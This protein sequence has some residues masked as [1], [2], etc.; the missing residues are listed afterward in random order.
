MEPLQNRF[1]HQFILHAMGDAIISVDLNRQILWVNPAFTHLFGYDSEEV[2]HRSVEFVYANP[3]DFKMQGKLRY[4]RYVPSDPRPYEMIY[5]RKDQTTFWG[6]ARGAVVFNEHEDRIGFTVAVRDITRRKQ[7]IQDL[8]LEKE[9]WFVTLQSIGDAVITTDGEGLVR[10]INPVAE[11]LTG[12]ASGDAIGQPIDSVFHIFNEYTRAPG[13]NPV[14]LAL[15]QGMVVG[16][17]NHTILL[18]RQGQELSIENSAAPI[19]DNEGRIQGCVMVFRD[20]TQK[21]KMAQRISW[22][23]NYDA[24]TGL[25]N[26]HLFQDRLQQALSR[27]H[28]SGHLV[29]LLYLDVDHFKKVNDRLGHPFGDRVLVELGQRFRDVLRETDTVCRLGGDEYGVILEDLL[30][31]TEA[32]VLGERLMREAAFPF[33]ID[34][35]RADLSV[36]VGVAIYPQDGTDTAALVKN[37]DIALFQVKKDGRNN[38]Q[39]FSEEMNRIVQMKFEIEHELRETLD[40]HG[41]FLLYQ[42]VYDLRNSQIVGVEALLRYRYQDHLRPPEE[43]IPVAEESGLIVPVGQWVLETAVRKIWSWLD[44]GLPL[45]RMAVNVSVRQIHS[46]SFIGLVETLLRDH[47]FDPSILE[48]ELTEGTLLFRD[49]HTLDT[50]KKLRDLGVRIS[51]DDFGTGYSSLNYLRHFPINTARN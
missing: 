29:A 42:P 28:R 25:P 11:E 20:V 34:D 44:R 9:Q 38:L 35:S 15:S 45:R 14:K 19:R 4:N 16:L 50:L 39:F 18:N 3:G 7:L 49:R 40:N 46:D 6:E 5:R 48:L 13:E 33:H 12:W 2:C 32:L 51:V 17:S 26:R 24:L 23:A 21:I 31:R 8:H 1:E 27:A 30:D 37:A 41:F 36:S 43:F 22:Q 47:R 10:Y